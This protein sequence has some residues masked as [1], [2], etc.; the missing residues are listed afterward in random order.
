[1][2]IPKNGGFDFIKFLVLAPKTPC[3]VDAKILIRNLKNKNFEEL[4]IFRVDIDWLCFCNFII[5]KLKMR[6]YF[7][8]TNK[9]LLLEGYRVIDSSRILVG[10]FTSLMLADMG[11][12][13]IK[14]E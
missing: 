10:A 7:S 5:N 13:V 12:E 3:Y 4:I 9:K 14:I 11:A 6:R 1:M 2:T 8:S